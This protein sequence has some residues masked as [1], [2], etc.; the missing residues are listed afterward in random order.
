MRTSDGQLDTPE[1]YLCDYDDRWDMHGHDADRRE[2]AEDA[3]FND[4]D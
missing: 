3:W 4:D 1:L 2:I